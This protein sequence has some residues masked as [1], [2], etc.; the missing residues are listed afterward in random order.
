VYYKRGFQF[1][2]LHIE[3][4]LFTFVHY[5]LQGDR[6]SEWVLIP[7]DQLPKLYTLAAEMYDV[8]YPGADKALTEA[9]KLTLGRMLLYSKQL[10]PPLSLL[11]QHG[12][13]YGE[14]HLNANELLTAHGGVAHF[15]FSTSPGLTLSV[16]ANTATA[17]WLQEGLHFLE[18]HY[19]F[20]DQLEQLLHRRDDD[21]RPL[22]L[23]EP[24]QGHKNS[25]LPVHDMVL[26]SHWVTPDNFACSFLRGLY[27]DLGLLFPEDGSAPCPEMA[28][29]VYPGVTQTDAVGY[30]DAC[31]RLVRRIH[32]QRDWKVAADGQNLRCGPGCESDGSHGH[33]LPLV[34]KCMT[35]RCKWGGLVNVDEMWEAQPDAVHVPGTDKKRGLECDAA[36]KAAPPKTS[37]G[38]SAG[39]A[40]RMAHETGQCEQHDNRKQVQDEL[41]K[42]LEFSP[43]VPDF[44]PEPALEVADD[45]HSDERSEPSRGG[46]SSLLTTASLS[47]ARDCPSGMDIDGMD[48]E[49]DH[50]PFVGAEGEWNERESLKDAP[51]GQ[52]QAAASLC[53]S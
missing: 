19:R 10:F 26:K 38:A 45:A 32:A 12:I 35:C 15:G 8:F 33:P 52:Q 24:L 42:A 22:K 34:H 23:G 5:Q 41:A 36:S 37:A 53:S 9:D 11:R 17:A 31:R 13:R 44:D 47:P 27:A 1:F 18:D 40:L 6:E 21:D 7:Y 28:L 29:C 4:M 14:R 20:L 25:L 49:H 43:P 16:A 39:A 3:Q 51:P 50:S 30:R 48:S 2:N 46:D